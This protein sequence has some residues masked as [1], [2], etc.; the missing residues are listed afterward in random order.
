MEWDYCSV[1]AV[2]VFDSCQPRSGALIQTSDITH[3]TTTLTASL[4]SS[5]RKLLQQYATLRNWETLLHAFLTFTVASDQTR[6]GA[7]KPR[8]VGRSSRLVRA[9]F[10]PTKRVVNIK[11]Q[12]CSTDTDSVQLLWS[13]LQQVQSWWL[14]T[15]TYIASHAR[16]RHHRERRQAPRT[17]CIV[18]LRLLKSLQMIELDRMLEALAVYVLPLYTFKS[19][20]LCHSFKESKA[21][22]FGRFD[23]TFFGMWSFCEALI[24]NLFYYQLTT[25]HQI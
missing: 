24:I 9:A 23:I 5:N 3:H 25:D 12:V 11:R 7:R 22:R 20:K 19:S 14:D 2:S 18:M 10:A 16:Q 17:D 8:T 4:A 1:T 13:W 6:H 15:G 21:D